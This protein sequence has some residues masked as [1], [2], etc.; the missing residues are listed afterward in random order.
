MKKNALTFFLFVFVFSISPPV[1]AQN[2]SDNS[3]IDMMILRGEINR[4]IDTCRQILASDTLNSEIYY[5]LGLAY[6]NTLPDDNSFDCFLKAAN[7]SPSNEKY[8]FMVAKAYYNSG[9][10]KQ[11]EPLLMALCANDSM[12]WPLLI[13]VS[14]SFLPTGEGVFLFMS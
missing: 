13:P 11:A 14:P 3:K 8:S 10:L 4:A 6:Q 2:K 7:L 1:L 9:K 12:N 5:K